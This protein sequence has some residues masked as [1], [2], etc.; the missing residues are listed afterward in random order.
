MT[1]RPVIMW[2]RND[3]R[4]QDNPALAHACAAQLPVLAVYCLEEKDDHPLGGAS[5]WW[6]HHSLVSLQKSLSVLKIKLALR[7]GIANDIISSLIKQTNASSIVW[8]RRYYKPDIDRDSALKK[9]L[10]DNDISV[11]TFNANLIREPWE[12]K[13]GSGGPY[14]VFT[15]FWK[16]IRKIGPARNNLS[17]LPKKIVALTKCPPSDRLEDWKLLPAKPDWADAFPDHWQA[18]EENAHAFLHDFLDGPADNYDDDRNIPGM[19]GTSR[20][21]PHLAFG[22]ISPLQI[23]QSTQIRVDAGKLNASQADKFLS[24]II[25]RDF[26][27]NLLYYFPNLP[28]APLKEKFAH[29]PWQDDQAALRAWQKGKTGYPI[30]DAGMRQLWATGWMHNRVRM[31]VAS[32]LIKHLRIRWQEG[33]AWFWDTL[34]DA[35]VANN[36]ASWQWVAGSGA[37]AS[38]YFRIFNPFG[39]GEK[40]D[41][42]GD[43]V[44]Q[45]VP[46]L[47]RLPNKFIH[48]PWTA[49]QEI[50][51]TANIELGKSYPHPIVDHK[52]A[53]EKALDA[54]QQI[55]GQ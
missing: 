19:D 25:W 47:T 44:R 17:Q 1:D 46:E 21:S 33:A 36:A 27:C 39:Q 5:R 38:P 12:V 54:Y 48:Q 41:P 37:D 40:F 42:Q 22:E 7:K 15:P 32:F 45:W 55:K 20:L 2:F 26:S 52:R 35:D 3:L 4:I 6:L 30:V 28:K 14:K 18:G 24:Q 23:W 49:P 34:V 43:Y 11:K 50:L 13:T 53:R 51:K 9:H 16:S 8:N 29:F 10:E 31:I